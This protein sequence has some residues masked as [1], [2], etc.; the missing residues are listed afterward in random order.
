MLLLALQK[1]GDEYL[2]FVA[3][4]IVSL[5][6][7]VG[8]IFVPAVGSYGRVWEKAAAGV[9]SIFVLVALVLIGV[10]AGLAVVYYYDELLNLLG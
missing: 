6:A 5:V 4:G 8:L 10:V 2:L 7:F 1:I 9:L 3:A